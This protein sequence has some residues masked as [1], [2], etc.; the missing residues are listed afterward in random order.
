MDVREALRAVVSGSPE[1]ALLLDGEA[2]VLALSAAAERLLGATGDGCIGRSL[3]QYVTAPELP[4]WSLKALER[5]RCSPLEALA[6]RRV[7]VEVRRAAATAVTA[8]LALTRPDADAPLFAAWLRDGTQHHAADCARREAERRLLAVG[9][10]PNVALVAAGADGRVT[11]ATGG[12]LEALGLAGAAEGDRLLVAGAHLPPFLDGWRR[13]CAGEASTGRFEHAGVIFGVRHAPVAGEDG[14]VAGTVSVVADITVERADD[15]RAAKLAF[16]DQLTGLPNRRE[17]ERVLHPAALAAEDGDAVAVLHAGLDDFKLINESLGRAAGDDLLREAAARL[18]SAVPDGTLVARQGGDE[19]TIVLDGL[20]GDGEAAA[21]AVASEVLARF[22]APFD[23]AGARF[24]GGVSLGIALAPRES[25]RVDDLLRRA[26]A[27][28]RHAKTAGRGRYAMAIDAPVGDDPRERLHL[29]TRLHDAIANDEL[30]LHY[31]PILW[32]GQGDPYGVEALLRWQDPEHGMVPPGAFI[33]LAESTGLIEPIGD[34]VLEELCRQVAGWRERGIA[35]QVH[36]NVSPRELR[37]PDYGARLLETIARYGLPTSTF[38]A[39]LTES[40]V[41][42]RPERSVPVLEE[43]R[44]AGLLIA[45]DDFGSQHSSL[46]RLKDLPADVLKI[47]RSFLDDV[48]S[49]PGAC[50]IMSAMLSLADALG[51]RTVAEGIETDAQRTWLIEKR[52]P[53]GQGYRLGRPAPAV[54]AAVPRRTAAPA[55]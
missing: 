53:L 8:D 54:D 23:V 50:E 5:G 39:E 19:F 31:Q 52:C 15:A 42:D 55:S 11:L 2:R 10:Q 35:P 25:R 1:P 36:F 27:A 24:F 18:R 4:R 3:W 21:R 12:A 44:R 40:S 17:V 38:T 26:D 41:M 30:R 51:M 32:L 48:P 34:W 43:L 47:D 13:A 45:I 22:H 49:D 16:R 46:G 9:D 6:D 33:G 7:E 28:M 29:A 37:S 20:H 14:D